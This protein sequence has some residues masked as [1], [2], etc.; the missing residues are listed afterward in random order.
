MVLADPF[1][2]SRCD[3]GFGVLTVLDIPGVDLPEV[4]DAFELLEKI[5][6][7]GS[8][9]LGNRGGELHAEG[10]V[11]SVTGTAMRGHGSTERGAGVGE[12]GFPEPQPLKSTGSVFRYANEESPLQVF[13]REL[14]A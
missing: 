14:E 12:S 11:G 2:P 8:A 13:V 10:E 5:K 1:A 4:V 7:G 9:G 6:E 3:R